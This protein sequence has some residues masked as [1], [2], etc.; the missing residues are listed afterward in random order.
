MTRLLCRTLLLLS[1]ALAVGPTLAVD[2]VP[3]DLV[4]PPPGLRAV[5]LSYSSS[6]RGEFYRDGKRQS[7]DT[8]LDVDQ[9]ALR[10]GRSFQWGRRPAYFYAQM[11]H[12]RVDPG[13]SLQ[14]VESN[15]G[16]GDLGLMLATW[17]YVDRAAGRYAGVAAYLSL[18]TGS[19]DP[20]KTVVLDTNAGRNRFSAALQAGYGQRLFGPF[21]WMIAGDVAVF[22]DN[23]RYYGP[24]AQE[25]TLSQRPLFSTQTALTYTVNRMTSL[26]LSYFYN[27]GGE[28]RLGPSDWDNRINLHRYG[29]TALV[30]LPFGRL[31]L[32]YG[33]DLTTDTGLIEETRWAI[34][35][36]RIF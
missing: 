32:E 12:S 11:G 27:T 22:G 23:D 33:G 8:R 10:I 13:G 3:Q 19:Y 15:A 26:G 36:S 1:S 4:P 6:E 29:I 7:R 30:R 14:P 34:K 24:Y 25:E 20:L 31:T 21:S 35:L 28:T 9:I 17:P 2:L 18:P 5:Q 16:I